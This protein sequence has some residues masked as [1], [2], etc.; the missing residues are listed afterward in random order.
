M[1]GATPLVSVC[2][3]SYNH[4]LYL[5]QCLDG[6]VMQ[7]TDF[8]FEIV[9]H[10][11]ASKDRSQEII[12]EYERRYPD[13]FNCILQTENQYSKD[14]R[15]L[16]RFVFP[17]ARGKYIALCECDDYWTDPLKLQKQ[18]DFLEGHPDYSMCF[19]NAVEHWEGDAKED[20]LFSS[21]EDKDYDAVGL[22]EYWV[23]PTASI[24]MRAEVVV[25]DLYKEVVRRNFL[26]G[27]TPL[28][29]TCASLGKVR[30]MSDVMSVYRRQKDGASQSFDT[31][32]Y[33]ALIQHQLSMADLF[34]PSM[35]EVK[36][37]GIMTSCLDGFVHSVRAGRP[38]FSFLRIAYE[39]DSHAF[40]KAVVGRVKYKFRKDGK[41]H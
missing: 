32:K 29:L 33:H 22:T 26:F 37:D 23:V 16:A 14:H 19:H 1:Q 3:L 12:R 7:E 35:P 41:K 10:D 5:R 31:G 15:I 40:W 8:P 20:Q 9:I 38:D 13:L 27:D 6:I 11:D 18:V 34:G 30:G 25:S 24:M 39:Y 36:H 17:E 28:I 4:E 2:C 21:V